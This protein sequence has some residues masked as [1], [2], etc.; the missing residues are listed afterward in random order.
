MK[1]TIGVLVMTAM[2]SGFIACGNSKAPAP[3]SEEAGPVEVEET[4]DST[5]IDTSTVVTRG[6]TES[7]GFGRCSESGCNCKSFK[8]RGDTCGNCGHAYRKHY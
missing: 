3:V 4:I 8:G 2:V 5:D 7:E 1:K 6:G